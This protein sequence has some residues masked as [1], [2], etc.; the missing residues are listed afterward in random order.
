MS[1]ERW[2]VA[3]SSLCAP[4]SSLPIHPSSLIP[5]PFSESA[6]GEDAREAENRGGTEYPGP[7]LLPLVAGH[8]HLIAGIEI[9]IVRCFPLVDGG[10]IN[11][12][13]LHV[14][15]GAASRHDDFT[16]VG[17]RH[18]PARKPDRFADRQPPRHRTDPRLR[19]I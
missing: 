16:N 18:R 10:K 1:D 8:D 17:V 12:D 7:N 15:V 5:H 6:G 3:Y 2:T 11:R 4:H 14:A 13:R 9:E 19:P